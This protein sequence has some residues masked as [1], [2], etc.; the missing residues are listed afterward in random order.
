LCDCKCFYIPTSDVTINSK[1][2]ELKLD[3]LLSCSQEIRDNFF[4]FNK[5]SQKYFEYRKLQEY[6]EELRGFEKYGISIVN[7]GIY[8]QSE[9][10]DGTGLRIKFYNPTNKTIKYITINIIGYNSVNDPVSS[11]GKYTLSP[12]CVGPIEPEETGTYEFD[13]LWFTDLVSNA[14]IK[15]IVVQYM[16]GPTKTISNIDPC[17]WT[18]ELEDYIFSN[19][20]SKL[21]DI[22]F[23][24]E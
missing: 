9:Y 3:S 2:D 10:T 22:K 12:K 11:G 19:S 4:A 16:N 17:I 13:Y 7:W 21:K 14:K 23:I 20:Y 1:E 5:F 18:D 8:D 15:S 6:K 24:D